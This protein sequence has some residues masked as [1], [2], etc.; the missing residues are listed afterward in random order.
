MPYKLD[1]PKIIKIITSYQYSVA[2]SYANEVFI[3][4]ENK[5][6]EQKYDVNIQT[7]SRV[8]F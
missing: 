8:I 7:L 3:C 6:I 1:L 2:V 4:G 5:G